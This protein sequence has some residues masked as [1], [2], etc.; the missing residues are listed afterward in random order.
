MRNSFFLVST[1]ALVALMHIRI[2][3]AA[4]VPSIWSI[5]C[6]NGAKHPATRYACFES[7][8]GK[9]NY[10]SEDL[11]DAAVVYNPSNPNQ[12]L[13]VLEEDQASA[14][15]TTPQYTLKVYGYLQEPDN[16]INFELFSHND[17]LTVESSAYC[18]SYPAPQII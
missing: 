11:H 13:V 8:E 14:T 7:Q 12:F 9:A 17:Q 18:Q 16:C 6:K 2:V 15:L 1:I 4:A 3:D 10:R 5:F